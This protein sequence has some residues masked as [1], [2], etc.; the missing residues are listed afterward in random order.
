MFVLGNMSWESSFLFP[1][2]FL[3]AYAREEKELSF[4]SGGT[5]KKVV[6]LQAPILSL[7]HLYNKSVILLVR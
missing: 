3:K 1:P 2:L 7:D 6:H 4:P 5:M